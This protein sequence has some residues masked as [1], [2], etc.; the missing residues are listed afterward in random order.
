VSLFVL[1]PDIEDRDEAET[2]QPFRVE[3]FKSSYKKKSHFCRLKIHFFNSV[4]IFSSTAFL[5]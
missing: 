1:S 2:F 4:L 3:V 5:F